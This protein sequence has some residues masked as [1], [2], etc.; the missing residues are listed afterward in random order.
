MHGGIGMTM[1]YDLGHLAKRLTMI[2]HRFG[3]TDY[4]MERFIELAVA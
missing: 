3:D 1:E 2:D 4:H